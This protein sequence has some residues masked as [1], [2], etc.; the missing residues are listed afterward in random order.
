MKKIVVQVSKE[1]WRKA[2]NHKRYRNLKRPGTP[3]YGENCPIAQS[4]KRAG[5]NSLWVGPFSVELGLAK[6]ELNA[7]GIIIVGAFDKSEKPK[8]GTVVLTKR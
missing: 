8:Y 2:K 7:N 6:Y 5:Y 4:L 1:D 3:A